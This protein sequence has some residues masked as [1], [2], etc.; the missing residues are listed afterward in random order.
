MMTASQQIVQG[1]TAKT[2]DLARQPVE[3]DF[4]WSAKADPY[5]VHNHLRQKWKLLLVPALSSV[6][7]T[8]RRLPTS[9]PI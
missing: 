1:N 2:P 8:E 3:L 7:S 6:F 5:S 4:R 9:C